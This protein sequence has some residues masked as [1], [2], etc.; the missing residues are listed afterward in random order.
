MLQSVL[1]EVRESRQQYDERLGCTEHFSDAQDLAVLRKCQAF[2]S[3][4]S[5]TQKQTVTVST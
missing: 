4:K 5:A 2:K 1:F 3:D